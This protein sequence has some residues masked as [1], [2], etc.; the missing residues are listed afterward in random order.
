MRRP[1]IIRH[2]CLACNSAAMVLNTAKGCG[3]GAVSN[4]YFPIQRD[5]NPVQVDFTKFYCMH[6]LK[7]VSISIVNNLCLWPMNQEVTWKGATTGYF[8]VFSHPPSSWS[9]QS[10]AL[11]F[12]G[13][14]LQWWP[15]WAGRC[16][17]CPGQGQEPRAI[18]EPSQSLCSHSPAAAAVAL[19]A[20]SCAHTTVSATGWAWDPACVSTATFHWGIKCHFGVL[21]STQSALSV[22][23]FCTIASFQQ[24]NMS[25]Q[26]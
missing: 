24:Q 6:Q 11:V 17:R 9:R 4:L 26:I 14:V 20:L 16:E 2:T 3:F 18:S 10:R 5:R 22:K 1:T 19:R 13:W 15:L 23:K 25:F 8:L 21:V 12:A 7:A